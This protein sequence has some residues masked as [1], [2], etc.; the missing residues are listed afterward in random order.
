MGINILRNIKYK[1]MQFVI[2]PNF[3]EPFCQNTFQC[4]R[5]GKFPKTETVEKKWQQKINLT[6]I[7]TKPE[8]LNVKMEENILTI[9]AELKKHEVAIERTAAEPEQELT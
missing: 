8:D 6:L 4:R 1:K 9:S 7:P 3:V 2:E 5:P